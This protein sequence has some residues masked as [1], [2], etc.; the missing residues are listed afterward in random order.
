MKKLTTFIRHILKN[1]GYLLLKLND[2][3]TNALDYNSEANITAFYNNQVDVTNYIKNVAT[4]HAQIMLNNLAMAKVNLNN[5]NIADVGCGTGHFLNLLQNNFTN[6]TLTGY[7]INEAPIQIAKKLFPTINY[8]IQSV[9]KILDIKYDCIFINH[10]LE[11]LTYPEDCLKALL[12]SLNPNGSLIINIPNGRLDTFSGHIHFFSQ[13]SLEL[14]VKRHLTFSH[15]Q[16][17]LSND[18]LMICA[19]IKI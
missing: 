15:Y 17:F 3:A 9:Y 1:R 6:T 13:T 12:A 8:K 11:H 7:E 14:L 19:I 16:S 4:T 2:V 10:V 18:A 5:Q